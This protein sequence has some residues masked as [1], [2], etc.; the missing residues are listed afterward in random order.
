MTFFKHNTFQ[1]SDKKL[2]PLTWNIIYS[3]FKCFQLCSLLC[4]NVHMIWAPHSSPLS[5][6]LN[7]LVWV[8]P[9]LPH[10]NSSESYYS[11]FLM[12]PALHRTVIQTLFCSSRTSLLVC[13]TKA[14]CRLLMTSPSLHATC[15]TDPSGL[16]L[17]HAAL[18][19]AHKPRQGT[20]AALLARS[21]RSHRNSNRRS[22]AWG[23]NLNFMRRVSFQLCKA[24]AGSLWAAWKGKG[25]CWAAPCLSPIHFFREMNWTGWCSGPDPKHLAQTGHL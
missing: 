21:L 12:F 20:Q 16:Q 23:G 18:P 6:I 25:E 11:S 19:R 7:L 24:A 14:S 2:L 1:D 3:S 8:V 22:A 13:A 5:Y 9:Q 10:K 15:W 17:R 4:H